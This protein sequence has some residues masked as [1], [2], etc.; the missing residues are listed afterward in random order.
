MSRGPDISNSEP[1][2]PTYTTDGSCAGCGDEPG[3]IHL[4][5][6][7]DDPCA[8]TEIDQVERRIVE[9]LRSMREGNL[10][11]TTGK[12]ADAIERGEHR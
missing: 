2:N 8:R 10:H 4:Q 9:W 11:T 5:I 12:L 3:D 1:Q 6:V 7:M